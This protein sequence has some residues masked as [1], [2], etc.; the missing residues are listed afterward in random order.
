VVVAVVPSS[1]H[2][3]IASEAAPHLRDGQT[4]VLYPGR[5]CAAIEFTKVLRDQLCGT[6]VIVA[7]GVGFC[8]PTATE[9]L[10]IP[11]DASGADRNEGV[12]DR[13]AHTEPPLSRRRPDHDL[14]PWPLWDVDTV[15]QRGG[16]M[17]S[18]IRRACVVDRTACWRRG[19]T[20]RKRGIEQLSVSELARYASDVCA[21][22]VR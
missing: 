20:V 9:R 22:L 12:R 11:Y 3:D 21:A 5:T 14:C 17:N 2:A 1:A 16:R 7:S 6:D 8:A 18:I 4:V 19:R 10:R 13:P 15:C